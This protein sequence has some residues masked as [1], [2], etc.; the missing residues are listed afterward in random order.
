MSADPR[1]LSWQCPFLRDKIL[2]EKRQRRRGGFMAKRSARNRKEQLAPDVT[3]ATLPGPSRKRTPSPYCYRLLFSNSDPEV[4]GCALLWQ[5]LGGREEYQVALER[6][7]SGELR[8]HCSC[9]DAIFR[10]ENQ[11][12]TCKHVRGLLSLGRKP[13]GGGPVPSPTPGSRMVPTCGGIGA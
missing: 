6:K 1:L 11:P 7:G 5:V 4:E 12:H 9:A 13:E 8:W 10:G 3:F 2:Q